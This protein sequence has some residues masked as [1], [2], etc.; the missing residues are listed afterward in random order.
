M[1]GIAAA[2]AL[3]AAATAAAVGAVAAVLAITAVAAFASVSTFA[4]VTTSTVARLL[5]VDIIGENNKDRSK[6]A[7]QLWVDPLEDGVE[8]RSSKIRGEGLGGLHK[9][10]RSGAAVRGR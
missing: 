9:V 3:A 10:V 8:L 6:L 5:L 4:T 1:V 7:R 2:A